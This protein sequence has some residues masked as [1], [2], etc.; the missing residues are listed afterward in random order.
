MIKFRSQLKDIIDLSLPAAEVGVADG[1]FSFE[2]LT[3]GV[4]KLYCVDLWAQELSLPGMSQWPQHEHDQNFEVCKYRLKGFS[5]VELLKG[6]SV[7]MSRHIPDK[8]LGF[9]YIDACH[10]YNSVRTDL[11][12]WLP[13]VVRGGVVGLHDY[14]NTDYGVNKAVNDFCLDRFDIITIPDNSP[15]QASCYFINK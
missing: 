14:L 11:N 1:K 5:N 2:I 8:S 6:S 15:E 4:V 13:K 9:V 10:D 7:K 12:I 3:W